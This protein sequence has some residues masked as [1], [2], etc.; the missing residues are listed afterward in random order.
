MRVIYLDPGLENNRGH[1]ANYCRAI[2][3]EL[4]HRAVTTL[5]FA[6]QA[7]SPE[8]RGELGAVPLFRTSPY[9]ATDGDPFAGALNAFDASSRSTAQDLGRLSGIEA[10]DL[11]YLTGAQPAPFMALVR[12]FTSLSDDRKPHVVMEFGTDPG[13]DLVPGAQPNELAIGTRDYRIDPRPMFYRFAAKHLSQADLA[14]FHMVTCDSFSSQIYAHVLGK[15]VGVLPLPQFTRDTVTSRVGRRPITVAVIGHQRREKGFHLMPMV[16]R[17]LL[18]HEADIRLLVHNGAPKE[19][20]KVQQELRT[21][22]EVDDRMIL[23]EETVDEQKWDALLAASDLMLCPYDQVRYSTSSSGVVAEALANAIPLIVPARTS[24]EMLLQRF[25]H[26]GV[27]FKDWTPQSIADATRA[28]IA[29]FDEIAGRAVAAS[30]QWN[31]TM[32]VGNMVTSLL[33]RGQQA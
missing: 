19:M 25:G 23:N 3:R 4:D 1:H 18:A 32:G 26:P 14:R 6:G 11:V 22:A 13:V 10:G 17:L 31:A 9:W 12:W 28:A 29:N 20:P 24:L 2:K 15:P 21:V 5:V 16:A 27:T 8:L 30:K 33:A 7:V